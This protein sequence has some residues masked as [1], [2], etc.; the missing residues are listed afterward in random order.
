MYL[1]RQSVM[2]LDINDLYIKIVVG[3]GKKIISADKI[4]T[5]EGAVR[6]R[7]IE[8][9]DAIADAIRDF[10]YNKFIQAKN[11]IF[12]IKGQDTIVRHTEVPIM[13][14]DKVLAS[15]KWGISQYIPEQG[16]GHYI[17]FQI[18]DKIVSSESKIYKLL[19]VAASKEKVDSYEEISNKLGMKLLAVDLAANCVARVFSD[20]YEKNQAEENIGII[21]IGEKES[22][23]IILEKGKLFIERELP[24]G[25]SNIT[26]QLVAKNGLKEESAYNYL[27]EKISLSNIN[28][29]DETEVRIKRLFDNVFSSFEKVIRFFN[30]GRGKNKL[31]RIYLTGEGAG[32]KNIGLYIQNFMDTEVTTISDASNLSL[33]ISKDLDFSAFV[34]TIGAVLRKNNN[35]ELNLISYNGNRG[36]DIFEKYKNVIYAATASVAVMLICIIAIKLY[37]FKLNNDNENLLQKIKSNVQV[38]VLNEKLNKQKS[39][40]LKHIYTVQ[41]VNKEKVYILQWVK[42]ITDHTPNGLSIS[43]VVQ[44]PQKHI[45]TVIGVTQNVNSVSDF[46][47]NL[48]NSGK[49]TDVKIVSINYDKTQ[50]FDFNMTIRK[51]EK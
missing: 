48:K 4:K 35:T 34:P 31:D 28:E 14:N 20:V 5:P 3:D 8:N 2:I 25:I 49:F 40:Y 36:Q 7:I 38:E 12:V 41:T 46:S 43:S 26:N 17:N 27:L 30:T 22:S 32:I 51:V 47:N 23:I 39:G 44:D 45:I 33:D 50:G 24:F 29:E 42:G 11:L 10:K 19:V 13:E 37:Y 1:L 21:D 16:E 6:N 15:A 18:L 9:T